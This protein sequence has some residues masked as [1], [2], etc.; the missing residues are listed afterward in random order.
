MLKYKFPFIQ[1]KCFD[2]RMSVYSLEKVSV[3]FK[4]RVLFW[5]EINALGVFLNFYIKCMYPTKYQSF[6]HGNFIFLDEN[7]IPMH[8]NDISMHKLILSC[9]KMINFHGQIVHFGHAL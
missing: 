8:E 1:G 4:I 5:P 2:K 6:I 7:E 9:M 3:F